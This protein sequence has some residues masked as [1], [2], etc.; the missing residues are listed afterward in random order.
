MGNDRKTSCVATS[1]HQW[2]VAN[3]WSFKHPQTTKV[4]SKA[5]AEDK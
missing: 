4:M 5:K 2:S 1:P 3:P